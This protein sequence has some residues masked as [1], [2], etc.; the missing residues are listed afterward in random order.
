M[1]V[2]PKG[3]S[4]EVLAALESLKKEQAVN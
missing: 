4:E 1:K 3:H 2:S